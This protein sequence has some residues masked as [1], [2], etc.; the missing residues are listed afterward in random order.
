ML[1]FSK[2]YVVRMYDHES[3]SKSLNFN[4]KAL[5]T[6]F[7]IHSRIYIAI[8]NFNPFVVWNRDMNDNLI[9]IQSNRGIF[10]RDLNTIWTSKHL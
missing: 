2:T 5:T 6:R 7:F 3:T 8:I 10:S 4:F 1:E 9:I